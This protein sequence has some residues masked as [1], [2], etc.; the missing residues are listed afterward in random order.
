MSSTE[1]EIEGIKLVNKPTREVLH[2][3][4]LTDYRAVKSNLLR[5]LLN[6]GKNPDR[7]EGYARATVRQVS[8]KTDQFYRW[9][10][11][12]NDTYT[13]MM[14][15]ADADEYMDHLVYADEDYS[16]SHLSTVQKCLKRVFKWR[17]IQKGHDAKWEPER[18]FSQSPI[19]ARDYLT[20]DGRKK[21]R[22]D[23]DFTAEIKGFGPLSNLDFIVG[24]SPLCVDLPVVKYVLHEADDSRILLSNLFVE[25]SLNLEFLKGTVDDHT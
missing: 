19:Q 21:I 14:S 7:A 5:W 17:R 12:E 6:E 23:D 1:E 13:V 15:P 24:I 8:Q 20:M 16:N 3:P 25:L 4:K 22:D 10:W 9:F 2:G 11:D 18:S